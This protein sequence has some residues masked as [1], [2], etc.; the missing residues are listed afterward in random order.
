MSA[1]TGNGKKTTLVDKTPEQIAAEYKKKQAIL[2]EFFKK[3]I[4]SRPPTMTLVQYMLLLAQIVLMRFSLDVLNFEVDG[5]PI[6][7]HIG[8]TFVH[9]LGKEIYAI[10]EEALKR[11][12]EELSLITSAEQ[13]E[14][15]FTALI[16]FSTLSPLSNESG[17]ECP[18]Q[19]AKKYHTLYLF[20]MYG[21]FFTAVCD[22]AVTARILTIEDVR[23]FFKVSGQNGFAMRC[24]ED[25]KV[26]ATSP[27]LM[28]HDA[29][30]CEIIANLQKAI[31][32]AEDEL[33]MTTKQMS[34]VEDK[35]K[36]PL[37]ASKYQGLAKNKDALSSK[38]EQVTNTLSTFQTN[39]K[40][41]QSLLASI[42]RVESSLSIGGT[43]EMF[44][45][46]ENTEDPFSK[47]IALSNPCISHEDTALKL[48]MG[49]NWLS[50]KLIMKFQS[51]HDNIILALAN[52]EAI[53]RMTEA[54]FQ[55]DSSKSPNVAEGVV[56]SVVVKFADG[57]SITCNMKVKNEG[58]P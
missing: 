15:V 41:L 6:N 38:M 1:P 29:K 33:T 54:G 32:K 8:T 39:M 57:R 49:M 14:V 13:F 43:V 58:A 55:G 47:F 56:V 42:H 25:G 37:L 28:T 5:K 24:D 12:F 45:P 7:A 9:F 30:V 17:T 50:L 40:K 20:G 44:Y 36:N 22:F 10:Q 35:L 21:T 4:T 34:D 27:S 23:T 53:R 31:K 3:L 26:K 16:Y 19:N 18:G 11:F 52:K 2:V 46:G 51:K 48:D